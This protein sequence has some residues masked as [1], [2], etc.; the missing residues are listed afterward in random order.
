MTLSE[1]KPKISKTPR[2][3]SLAWRKQ[4]VKKKL[5][6]EALLR[7]ANGQHLSV[8]THKY[9]PCPYDF[10]AYLI[11]ASSKDNDTALS[12]SIDCQQKEDIVSNE[13]DWTGL[14]KSAI[15]KDTEQTRCKRKLN[16]EEIIFPQPRFSFSAPTWC[17]W[18]GFNCQ[19]EDEHK[20]L[21]K[22]FD[23]CVSCG[24]FSVPQIEYQLG[25]SSKKGS[26]VYFLLQVSG[27]CYYLI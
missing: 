1:K 6:G 7:K 14:F 2:I 11:S 18:C 9:E 25:G 26:H 19:Q 20:S 10:N 16:Y 4:Q 21:K 12:M 27:Y 5:R 22:A 23:R 17:G 8:C 13:N 3:G 24:Q 15:E